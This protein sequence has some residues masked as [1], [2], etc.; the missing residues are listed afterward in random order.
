[1]TPSVQV[2]LATF[3]GANF[4]SAQL[5]SLFNQSMPDFEILVADDGSSD[6]TVAI[7]EAACTQHPGRLRV[8]HRERVGGPAAN[9]LRLLD[10]ADAP[11]LMFCDQDDVWLPDK[12]EVML[13]AI[14]QV[15]LGNGG[16]PA[17]VHSDLVVVDSQLRTLAESFF[18]LHALDPRRHALKELL[19]GNCVV[20]CATIFNQA[21][22][23][24]VCGNPTTE[25]VM[26]DWWLA[27]TASA[28]G[29]ICYLDR[30]TTLYRQHDRNVLG[31]NLNSR[32]PWSH[33]L[34]RLVAV[35]KGGGFNRML[36]RSF[37]Q[38]DAFLAIHAPA[39]T[40]SSRDEVSRVAVMAHQG[41][42][43]RR[44]TAFRCGLLRQGLLRNIATLLVL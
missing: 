12:I 38:A 15:E 22:A 18:E 9:F 21:L 35:A 1:M 42:L 44:Y 25:I 4:L 10:A 24:L 8:I 20:G 17:L 41:A 7:L 31:A 23:R 28:L 16:K 3:N 13:R 37:S 26:H 14:E 30:A 6:D 32:S 33:F 27:I 11:Y 29:S 43:Q 36:R 39:L 2:L 40:P 19:L 34:G 5:T